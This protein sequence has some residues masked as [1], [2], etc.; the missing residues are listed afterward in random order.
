MRRFLVIM[1]L[2]SSTC[3]PNPVE[4]V[5]KV[6][7]GSLACTQMV[8][9][10]R[11]NNYWWELSANGKAFVPAGRDSNKVGTCTISRNPAA[12]VFVYILGESLFS[13]HMVADKPTIRA[14]KGPPGLDSIRQMKTLVWSCN[15]DCLLWPGHLVLVKTGDV[16]KLPGTNLDL[17]GIS[18]DLKTIVAE[19]NTASSAIERG[20]I[21]L[22]L[23][24]SDTGKI[25]KRMLNRNIHGWL[26]DRTKGAEGVAEQF[27]WV[28]RSGK[29][30]LAYP[31]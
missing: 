27:K 19:D 9:R 29:D 26:L 17:I 13:F 8:E 11:V 15:G 23:I 10:K 12:N 6:E 7:R 25:T 22:V 18:P 5:E 3:W 24:D 28:R 21:P 4:V 30:E 1:A 20:L 14:I 16:K 2:T 31:E